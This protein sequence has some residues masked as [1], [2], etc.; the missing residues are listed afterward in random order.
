MVIKD[1]RSSLAVLLLA[2]VIVSSVILVAMPAYSG[3]GISH[4][5]GTIIE[6]AS[7]E[8]L[9]L[10]YRL[11]YNEPGYDGMFLV[12][13]VWYNYE[14]K[15]S[16]NLTYLSARA[17][18]DNGENLRMDVTLDQTPSGAD[19][20]WMLGLDSSSYPSPYDDNF[21]VDIW[22]RAAGAGN[23]PHAPRDNHP[24][25]GPGGLAAVSIAES[26]IKDIPGTE[27]PITIRILG[28]GV[29][30]SISPSENTGLPMQTLNYTI[31][32]K[33]TG[34]LDDN[35]DLTV[36]DNAGW[37][38]TL[39]ENLIRVPAGENRQT[40][41]SV[42][43][44]VNALGCTRDNITATATSRADNKVKGSGACI[45]HAE[46]V[47]SVNVLISPS[48]Q[49]NLPG[50]NLVYTVTIRNTGNIADTYALENSDNV[51]W[52]LSLENTSLAIP[53][54]ENRTTKLTVTIPDNAL[55]CTNDNIRVVAISQEN[56]NVRAENSCVAHVRVVRGVEVS[57]SPSY[58]S[59]TPGAT[60][61]YTVMVKNTGNAVGSYG[62][63]KGDD[64]GWTLVLSQTLLENI[65]PT[66]NKTATLIVTIPNN[67]AGCTVDNIWV[68][69]TS[70]ENADVK[71]NENCQAHAAIVKGVN[72]SI[73]PSE[74]SGVSGATL[75]YAVT[76]KNT[77]NVEDTYDLTVSDNAGWGDNI[78]LED[79]W[80][81]VARDNENSTTLYVHIPEN[82][83]PCTRDNVVVTA[84]SRENAEVDNS[85]SCIAH[86]TLPRGVNVSI[87]PGYQDGL[88]G[89]T[90]NYTVTVK[91]TGLLD[92]NY[93]LTATDNAG[94]SLAISPASLAVPVG[95]NRIATLSVTIP[96]ITPGS[97]R[98]NIIVI[99][100]SLID[101]TVSAE[102]SCIAHAVGPRAENRIVIYP[103]ADVYAFGAFG[104]GYSRSQ[105]KFDISDILLQGRI[106]SAKLW[107]YRL[108]VDNWD[109]GVLLN[110]VDDQLWGE[111]ITAAEFDNQIL[112][113]EEN[114][115]GKFMSR[116]WDYLNVENQL[117][118]DYEA[119][120]IYSSYRLRWAD[121]NGSKPS[122]GIDDGRFLVINSEV[123]ELCLIFSSCE[124]DGIDPYLEVVYVPPY[125]VSVLISP[126]Y[127]S[128]QA[129]EKLSYTVM[130]A[131]TGNLDD[132]Y[133]LT[134]S[135]NAGWG[136]T[137]SP[138]SLAV[139][140]GTMGEAA[141]TVTVPENVAPCT[142]DNI[143]VTATSRADSRV[144]NDASCIAH[145]A[146]VEFKLE[147]LYK[148][149]L[150]LNLYLD[151]GS[152]L[153]VKFYDY[154]NV[155]QAE[156]VI[157][158]FVPPKHV[159]N[160][161]NVPH[162]SGLPVEIVTLALTT[163]NT[164]EVISTIG[165]FT[166]TKSIL[167]ARYTK[168]KTEYV[169]PEADKSALFKEYTRIKVQYVR[170]P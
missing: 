12:T 123:D 32:V 14:N 71:D 157:D 148:V 110:R 137:I 69:A 141:L 93:D 25:L 88:P 159:E 142:M 35:Y 20:M 76:V 80:L 53:P 54:F 29:E 96:V 134:V 116:G 154:W 165:S 41:L 77:G 100:T 170:A 167:F 113:N 34:S 114:R 40:T 125:A 121:D 151:N 46:N 138:T 11:Y 13:L 4:P 152:K 89:T 27:K 91:N 162:P 42:T 58:Q 139:A 73:L 130:V 31:T 161:E 158:E 10:R 133:D 112:T 97:T 101:N 37:G 94:W 39:L 1:F 30:V 70:M 156:S 15:P 86:A 135:D 150:D 103:V 104:V 169:K 132:N 56:E 21:T 83:T 66:E 136:P 33:N 117:N 163:D 122:V 6:V 166:V 28:R 143:T 75:I 48:Y 16:E 44:P 50:E 65:Q 55:P 72:V 81:W 126:T 85:D 67:A 17:Y 119:G 109:G 23:V 95:E 107:L 47:R 98:D 105:L 131:N 118:V 49:E 74:N 36:S 147:N 68:A 57:I 63:Q 84:T 99:A 2:F 149:S 128:G 18:W 82:T 90:L 164:E 19:T 8:N 140:S 108:A 22:M 146:K 145:R 26:T 3:G 127:K 92:D 153:V 120:Y 78:W 9:L 115:A 155:F 52:P 64:L 59:G 124:Y 106:I 43:I 102:N 168:I 7:G 79:N 60:L 38:P 87:S 144:S 111:N 5:H 61:N 51:G 45:A 129:G 24:I 62:L 160:I